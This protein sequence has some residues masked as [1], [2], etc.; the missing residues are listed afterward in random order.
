MPLIEVRVTATKV[1]RIPVDMEGQ[2]EA[3]QEAYNSAALDGWE[4]TDCWVESVEPS[5]PSEADAMIAMARRAA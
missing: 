3:E 5:D 4:P 2:D 1:Y